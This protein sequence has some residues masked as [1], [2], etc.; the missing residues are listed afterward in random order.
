M[1]KTK[2]IKKEVGWRATAIN[3]RSKVRVPITPSFHTEKELD[4]RLEKMES[5]IKKFYKDVEKEELK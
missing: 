5:G 1:A 3:K 2:K 4:E